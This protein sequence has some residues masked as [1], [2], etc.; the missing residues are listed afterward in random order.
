MLVTLR[1]QKY[2]ILDINYYYRYGLAL[3]ND[4]GGLANDNFIHLDFVDGPDEIRNISSILN[5]KDVV[6]S[7]SNV[8]YYEEA[9]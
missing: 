4:A 5:N 8:R 2:G 7:N 3:Y 1:T 6:N 9:M